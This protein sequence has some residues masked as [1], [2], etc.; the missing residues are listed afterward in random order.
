MKFEQQMKY[1]IIITFYDET[2]HDRLL[3]KFLQNGHKQKE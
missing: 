3:F 2:V 1:L